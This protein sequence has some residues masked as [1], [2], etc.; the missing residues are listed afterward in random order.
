MGSILS[1]FSSF[2]PNSRG[3]LPES[4]DLFQLKQSQIPCLSGHAHFVRWFNTLAAKTK[5]Q[6]LVYNKRSEAT[7]FI[8]SIV[9]RISQEYYSEWP[10]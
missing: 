6:S 1:Q 5:L 8:Q 7:R 4:I 3:V 2:R 10:N 9:N